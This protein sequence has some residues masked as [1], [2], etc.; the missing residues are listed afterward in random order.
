MT[1]TTRTSLVF[2]GTGPVSRT[3]L[4]GIGDHFDIEAVVTKPDSRSP[5]GHPHPTPVKDWAKAHN[6]PLYQPASAAELT[7]LVTPSP[8]KSSVGLVVD[9]G[10]L[11]PAPAI[12]AFPRG[13]VNSHFSLLPEWRGADPITFAIL[14]GQPTTGVSLMVI[15]PALD[16]GDL[17]AEASYS[18]VHDAT[19]A[20]LTE[21][22]SRLSNQLLIEKLPSYAVGQ[23]KPHPQDRT[24]TPT[25]SRKLTKADGII[26]WSKPA[27]VIEREIRAYLGWP[28][29]RTT[30]AGVDVIVTSAH[31]DHSTSDQPTGTPLRT[32]SGE[33]GVA[34]GTEVLVID[35]LKPA[36]KRDMTARDFLAGHPLASAGN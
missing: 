10:L 31:I 36:G 24:R 27:A 19:T 29:S 8:F 18:I 34:T 30:I 2:F 32:A 26:D 3:C 13:I 16:E 7:E 33:L 9:Y 5:H 1:D 15:V 17:I 22:L 25:Y 35:S 11:I 20:Q 21:A 23:L 14:S 28:G 4:E 6:R 12:A